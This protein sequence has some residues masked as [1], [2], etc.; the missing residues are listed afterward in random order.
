MYNICIIVVLATY[1]IHTCIPACYLVRV[2]CLMLYVFVYHVDVS[3][4]IM[5]LFISSLIVVCEVFIMYCRIHF[6]LNTHVN[7]SSIYIYIHIYIYIYIYT[8]QL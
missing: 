5:H 8:I 6:A 2:H 4:S 3:V 1:G 7:Y